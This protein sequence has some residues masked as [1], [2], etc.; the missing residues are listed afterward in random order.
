MDAKTAKKKATREANRLF[1]RQL[2]NAIE[3]SGHSLTSFSDVLGYE[4]TSTMS[5]IC[6][7]VRGMGYAKKLEAAKMLGLELEDLT[8]K[9][10]RSPAKFKLIMAARKAAD[11]LDE[12]SSL[13]KFLLK[14]LTDA[15][16]NP[17]EKK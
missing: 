12:D 9:V 15:T 10:E 5:Q 2:R 6:S 8:G 16:E 13:F 7:G 11:T 17:S 3:A 1:G 14:A 4:S